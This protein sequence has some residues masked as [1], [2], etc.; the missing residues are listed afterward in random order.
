MPFDISEELV[1]ATEQRL[2]GRLPDRYRS[3]M[4]RSNGGSV[5]VADDVWDLHPIA[6]TSDRKR[7][8]RTANHIIAETALCQEWPSF[9]RSAIA[10]AA[11]GAG[12]RLVIKRGARDFESTVYMW[13]HETGSCDVVADEFSDL[14]N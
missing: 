6:D 3:A 11:N 4:M 5:E 10:I 12:D 8:G 13:S 9:P 14:L 7:L 2:G 1:V